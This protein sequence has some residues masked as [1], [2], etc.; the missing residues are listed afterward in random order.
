MHALSLGTILDQAIIQQRNYGPILTKKTM[1]KPSKPLLYTWLAVGLF[2]ALS[3]SKS[4]QLG[5]SL[6]EDQQSDII[7]TDTTTLKI[8]TVDA[9]PVITAARSI[10]SVGSYDDPMWGA[11]SA[12]TYLNFRLRSTGASFSNATL[13]SVVL[14]LDYENTGQYGEILQNK[15]TAVG[16]VWEI[17]RLLEDIDE[18]TEYRSD[19]SLMTD[20][21]NLLASNVV[22]YPNDTAKVT[23]DGVTQASH[24]RIRLDAPAG[25]AL[26]NDLIN[27][28]GAAA[29]I[30][31]SN[32][33]FKDWFKGIH[34]RPTGSNPS[35]GSILRFSTSSDLTQLSVYYT[36]NSSGTP[37]K[38]R[39]DYLTR[40][41]AESVTTFTHNHPAALTDNLPTDTVVY[42]QG[43]DGLHAKISMPNLQN[44]GDVIINKAELVLTI[45]D[46]TTSVTNPKPFLLIAKYLNSNG[47]LDLVSDV[48]TTLSRTGNYSLFGG[49]LRVGPNGNL[50]Y[51]M[52]LTEHFQRIVD[53]EIN[54]DIYITLPS[55]L[56]ATRVALVN[57]KG[58]L[59]AKL[60]LTYT[61]IR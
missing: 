47:K 58:A 54:P 15:P 6:V 14:L 5:L 56:D 4:S 13:D 45:A 36:D 57:E 49:T 2:S 20:D 10:M 24:L 61:K 39:I 41:D 50:I 19:A 11:A 32:N 8:T 17:A 18:S 25:I 16:Q 22:F 44:L 23:V 26:G 33:E 52:L 40:Q 48:A 60:Y 35:N 29:N 53:E 55:A 59:A 42:V 28:Q 37:K 43:M 3:C 46:T 1:N 9:R 7:F 31:N 34:I 30:Y 27:P 38:K 12:S 21:A 51:P